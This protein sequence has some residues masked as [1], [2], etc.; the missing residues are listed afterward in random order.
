MSGIA[1]RRF[2]RSQYTPIP[3]PDHDFNQQTIIVTGGNRGIGL[4]AARHFL[5]FN[6]SKVILAMRDVDQGHG[7]IASMH[8]SCPSSEGVVEIWE[9]DLT[10]PETI[11][12]FVSRAMELARLDAVILN[13]GMATMSFQA[14]DGVERTL[15]TNVVGTFLLAIGL[16]PA[17][18]QSALRCNVRPRLVLVSSQGHQSAAFVERTADDIFGALND[19]G[20]ADM[21]DRYDTTKLLQLLAFYALRDTID[22]SWPGSITF[23]AVDPGLCNTGLTREMPLLIRIIHRIMKM[24]LA[25]TPE[26]GGRCI[27]L[28]AVDSDK[29][30]YHGGY[31]KDGIIER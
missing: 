2:V 10:K 20:K 8:K 25:R 22:Q 4:E 27:V 24:L 5:R 28:A 23:T 13:A 26:V 19:A 6:A 11:R 15:A 14:V 29:G 3:L 7:C 1:L 12:Q 9:L 21:A 16:L 18:H 17:L 30:D 31:F